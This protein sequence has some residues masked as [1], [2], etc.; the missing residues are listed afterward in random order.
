MAE[1]TL[2]N[3]TIVDG[4][5]GAPFAGDVVVRGSRIH[6]IEPPGTAHHGEVIDCSGALLAPGFID[7]HSHSDLTLLLDPRARSA[8]HQGVTLEVIGNCGHG[9]APLAD[10]D[11]A[12]LAMYGP[13]PGEGYFSWSSMAE[14][15]D[16][17]AAA[18]PAVNVVA[19]VPNGQLRLATLGRAMRAADAAEQAAM[20]KALE[21]SL[22]AGAWGLSTG[23][24]YAQESATATTEIDALC[25]IVERRD[26]LYATHTRHR[27]HRALAAIDEAI[28]TAQRTGVRLQI[29]HITPR[30]GYDDARRALDR[31]D[32]AH[33]AGVDVG[34][35]MHTRLHGFT[36]LRNLL[37]LP[38]QQGTPDELRRRLAEPAVCEAIRA[39]PNLIAGVGDWAKVTV[40]DSIARPECNGRTLAA[41]GECEG[42]D[43]HAAAIGILR[44]DAQHLDRPMVLLA[45]YTEP[46]QRLT[47]EHPACIPGSDATTLAP[48]GVLAGETF[49]GAYTWAAWFLRSMVRETGALTLSEGI[50]RL[51]S[52]PAER[53]GLADRGRIARGHRADIAVLDWERYGERGTLAA[54]SQLARGIRH[55]FVNGVATLRDGVET[56]QRAG[57]VIRR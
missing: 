50:R 37:P 36:H 7:I 12:R 2:S 24:E 27:D 41:I 29:S 11:T 15:F 16:R 53:L 5:A 13:I 54:P 56:G 8:I 38:L 52:M 28:G 55:L 30:S 42:T 32:A 21:A 25:A 48:D 18:A 39:H 33:A 10:I 3:A 51:T 46:M 47:F 43:G 20:R 14:Y 44:A 6:G 31:V 49:H 23:L 22:E 35:D 9:C 26:G 57:E 34:F 45:T 1:L 4:S 19:L 17:L 40:I